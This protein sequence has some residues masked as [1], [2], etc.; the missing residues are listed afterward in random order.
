MKPILP[1][2]IKSIWA[3]L[4]I[5]SLAIVACWIFDI[6]LMLSTLCIF[7]GYTAAWLFYSFFYPEPDSPPDPPKPEP[8]LPNEGS[9]SSGFMI[10]ETILSIIKVKIDTKEDKSYLF[11]Q[12]KKI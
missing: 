5:Y 3:F 7:F 12:N 9:N 4:A 11:I 1:K 6:S 10:N 2:G 8:E